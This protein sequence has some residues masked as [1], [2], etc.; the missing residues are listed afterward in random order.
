MVAGR[1]PR[2]G[3]V[4]ALEAHDVAFERALRMRPV[5]HQ[6][7]EGVIHST[8][9]PQARS[10]TAGVS[11]GGSVSYRQWSV[12]KP[13]PAWPTSNRAWYREARAGRVSRRKAASVSGL[14]STV[15]RRSCCNKV[16]WMVYGVLECLRFRDAAHR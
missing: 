12:S 14:P 10:S 1:V 16:S 3:D 11:N 6:S 7:N 15:A 8:R 2:T 4:G 13:G 5:A 9:I